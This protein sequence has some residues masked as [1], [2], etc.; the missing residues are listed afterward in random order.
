M[1]D[2]L[3]HG[4]PH[5]AAA[6]L[7]VGVIGLGVMGQRMLQRLAGHPRLRAAAVWDA[8]AD[9]LARTLRDYPALQG[10]RSAEQLIACAGLH[11]LYVA[12]PPAQHLRLSNAAFDAGVAVL[13]ESPLL[14]DTGAARATLRR[15]ER[16]GQRAAVNL[17]L[18][19]SPVLA[20]LQQIF[21]G[22]G[23]RPLGPLREVR[24]D[25]AYAAWP[26]PFQSRAG[27]WLSQRA[28]GGFVREV[29]THFIFALQ[30]VLGRATVRRSAT[31]YPVDGRGAETALLADLRA[32]GV[33]VRVFGSVDHGHAVPDYNRMWWRGGKGEIALFDWF[34]RAQLRRDQGWQPW[35]QAE[36]SAAGACEDT[37]DQWLRL[38]EGRA[39]LLP[40][41][42][43]AL[44]A[45]ETVEAL[46]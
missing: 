32:A 46:L 23:K 27:S 29:L 35:A 2:G 19:S 9:T 45:Q 25:L 40:G 30:R 37:C 13:C 7:D 36:L 31:R 21:G 6:P 1:D 20:A 38:I 41:Y 11:G 10:A 3:R 43:E 16:E 26:R 18:A 34:A 39:H 42:G 22:H 44:A 15:I 12:T 24:I 17:P 14:V 33:P 8:D 4:G 28:Q 5:G